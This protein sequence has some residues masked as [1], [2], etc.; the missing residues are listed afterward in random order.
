[1]AHEASFLDSAGVSVVGLIGLLLAIVLLFASRSRGRVALSLGI[2]TL[3]FLAA[4][5][6]AALYFLLPTPIVAATAV[7]TGLWATGL[8]VRSRTPGRF[9]QGTLGLLGRPMVQGFIL[10]VLSLGVVVGWPLWL[11]H[12]AL[13]GMD[14]DQ[15]WGLVGGEKPELEPETFQAATDRGNPLPL[16]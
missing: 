9:T 11:E 4:A 15:V 3:C 8:V 2:I 12:R 13:G 14:E 7:L 5:T 16:F 1:M 10:L 6:L